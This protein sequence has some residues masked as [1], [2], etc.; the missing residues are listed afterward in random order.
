M[1]PRHLVTSYPRTASPP[2]PAER[3]GVITLETSVT[4]RPVAGCHVSRVT[5][6]EHCHHTVTGDQVP[7]VTTD[8]SHAVSHTLTSQSRVTRVTQLLVTLCHAL[9]R[10]WSHSPA[11]Y[12]PLP[13]PAGSR[14]AAR[15]SSC[16]RGAG[17]CSVHTSRTL[18]RGA[19]RQ[20]GPA[21]PVRGSNNHFITS[22]YPQPAPTPSPPPHQLPPPPWLHAYRSRADGGPGPPSTSTRYWTVIAAHPRTPGT[23]AASTST[24][25]AE[26]EVASCVQVLVLVPLLS[27]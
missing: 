6:R 10:G 24:R 1:T 12:M 7:G 2:P 8:V 19:A 9:S 17:C 14:V 16:G 11:G 23:L 3:R 13:G 15:L 25:S 26:Q 21:L 5:W 4:R 27:P 22:D 18:G 20:L